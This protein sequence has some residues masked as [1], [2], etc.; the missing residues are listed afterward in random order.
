MVELSLNMFTEYLKLKSS[1]TIETLF[2]MSCH[3]IKKMGKFSN[4]CSEGI[5]F[6]LEGEIS[7][8]CS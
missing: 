4:I 1:L 7:R 3:L 5:S 2:Q 8:C 6:L